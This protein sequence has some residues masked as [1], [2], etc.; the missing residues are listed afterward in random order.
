MIQGFLI[1]KT[2]TIQLQSIVILFTRMLCGFLYPLGPYLSRRGSLSE[3]S[4]AE[5]EWL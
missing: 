2:K 3:T 5:T 1:H 4:T